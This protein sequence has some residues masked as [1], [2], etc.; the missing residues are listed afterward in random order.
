VIAVER[1]G[2]T[3]GLNV[4]VHPENFQQLTCYLVLS[5]LVINEFGYFTFRLLQ[6]GC[7]FIQ[8]QLETF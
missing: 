8:E 5:K 3:I 2:K 4:S 7:M 1:D 6:I